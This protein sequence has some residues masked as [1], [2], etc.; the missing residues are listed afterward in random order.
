MRR[1]QAH[2]II[3]LLTLFLSSALSAAQVYKW[4]DDNGN[5]H[6]GSEPPINVEAEKFST[7]TARPQPSLTP[8]QE[9]PTAKAKQ[10]PSQA[11][12]DEK[13]RRQVAKEQAQLQQ[14][15]TLLRENL[16]QLKNNPR[17]L[18]EIDGETVRLTEEQRQE[19]IRETEE[20]IKEFCD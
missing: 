5:V 19:R 10:P 8:T 16:A 18:A 13:V 3:G 6:F 2:F 9:A 14:E 15:C 20:Q 11:E 1:L 12:I 7:K 17:L 4:V